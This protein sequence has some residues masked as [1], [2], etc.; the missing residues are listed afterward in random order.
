MCSVFCIARRQQPTSIQSK[1]SFQGRGRISDTLTLPHHPRSDT[2]MFCVPQHVVI[3]FFLRFCDQHTRIN[4]PPTLSCAESSFRLLRPFLD[5][6]V[7]GSVAICTTIQYHQR[8]DTHFHQP[9]PPS[10]HLGLQ[11][12]EIRATLEGSVLQRP[13]QP[14][15]VLEDLHHAVPALDLLLKK[16]RENK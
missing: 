9:S 14:R 13:P 2:S 10:L 1:R 4:I 5:T 6:A 8:H 7:Y 3:V 15:L 16:Q 11:G 12:V